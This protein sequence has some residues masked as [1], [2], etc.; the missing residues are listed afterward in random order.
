MAQIIQFRKRGESLKETSI[1]PVPQHEEVL[2][3]I[4]MRMTRK[5]SLFSV[6]GVYAERLQF[7]GYTLVKALNEISDRI[8][9]SG[10]AGFTASPSFQA[11][12]SSNEPQ[13]DIFHLKP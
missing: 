4:E 12:L 1:R 2:G 7:A 9:S 6:E 11:K 13:S 10:T 3:R 8:C 5:G